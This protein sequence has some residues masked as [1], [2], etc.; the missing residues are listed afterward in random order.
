MPRPTRSL[1]QIVHSTRASSRLR[2]A[3]VRAV[4]SGL[5]LAL[6]ADMTPRNWLAMAMVLVGLSCSGTGGGGGGIGGGNDNPTGSGGGS[7]G[8]GGSGAGTGGSG[9]GT[10]GGGSASFPEGC[11]ANVFTPPSGMGCTAACGSC[12]CSQIKYTCDKS[13]YQAGSTCFIG[14]DP[15]TG[16][17]RPGPGYMAPPGCGPLSCTPENDLTKEL[18]LTTSAARSLR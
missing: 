12:D 11:R 4:G 1:R 10:G 3:L 13:C 18:T 15:T 16:T 5:A 2:A 8:S 7:A 14:A 6:P 9:A 17:A